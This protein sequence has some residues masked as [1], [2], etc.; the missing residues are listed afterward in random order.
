MLDLILRSFKRLRSL[1]N[2][3]AIKT[4]SWLADMKQV[5][6]PKFNGPIEII[7]LS[8]PFGIFC[9]REARRNRESSNFVVHVPTCSAACSDL[10]NRCLE[11]VGSDSSRIPISLYFITSHP[12][13]YSRRRCSPGIQ[14]VL[15]P[16]IQDVP[17]TTGLRIL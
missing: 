6:A 16:F 15:L 7:S 5:A 10:R 9:G 2:V 14:T 3:S 12:R 17:E 8:Q 4:L 1:R 11:P 13:T